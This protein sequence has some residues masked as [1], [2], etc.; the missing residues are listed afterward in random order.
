MQVV[1]TT[2]KRV[3]GALQV[4]VSGASLASPAPGE[5]SVAPSGTE[6]RFVT[7]RADLPGTATLRASFGGLDAVSREIPVQPSGR[8]LVDR[9]G[10][11]LGAPRVVELDEPSDAPAGTVRVRLSAFPGA[12]ALVRSEL[13]N[14][15]RRAT[16]ADDAYGLLLAGKAASLLA[17]LGDR[18]DP[19]AVRSLTIVMQQR[20]LADTRAADVATAALFVEG[21]SS[22]PDNPVLSRLAARLSAA[23]AQGQRP[24]GTFQ[25]GDGWTLQRLLVTTA[26][27]T[28]AVSAAASDAAGKVRARAVA[29]RASGAFER[30]APEI[31][32]GY[33]AA[34]V[35]SSGAVQGA[36]A[37]R[38][39]AVVKGALKQG[40]GGARYLPVE[41][42]GI[43]RADGSAPSAVEATALAALGLEGETRRRRSRTSAPRSS[44][45]TRRS[46]AGATAT[47]TSPRFAAVHLFKIRSPPRCGS[48][49][50]STEDGRRGGSPR[51]GQAEGGADSGG[52]GRRPLAR[53]A[54]VEGAR[55]AG[56]R[57]ARVPARALPL[58]AVDRQPPTER[59]RARRHRPRRAARR[60]AGRNP[61]LRV[62][63]RRAGP[64][65]SHPG[66]RRPGR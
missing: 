18:A 34:A 6:V 41:A 66:R 23:V 52:P 10:G 59:D 62:Q 58:A 1:N 53:E 19:D 51:P 15:S 24:D 8:P 45:P 22:Q 38:L 17:K 36:L 46:A 44:A 12:L 16:L 48:S 37:E 14:V 29:V 11:T 49:S 63:P 54:P 56:G 21:A 50:S 61:A 64:R 9:R 25:G 3:S 39:R 43:V 65:D 7:L 47:P 27:C 40:E 32:D 13:S 60:P 30:F 33:T 2:A 28:R 4:A 42:R 26:E 31:K 55:R 5:I 20:A 57:R 35:L